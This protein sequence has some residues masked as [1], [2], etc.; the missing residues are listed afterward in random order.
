VL[1]ESH[2][3]PD[4][5]TEMAAQA[6]RCRRLARWCSGSTKNALTLMADDYDAREIAAAS[7]GNIPGT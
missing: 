2:L 4:D 6:R 7:K 3:M 1:H 5:P